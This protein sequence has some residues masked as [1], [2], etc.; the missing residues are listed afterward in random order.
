MQCWSFIAWTYDG[1]RLGK[2]RIQWLSNNSKVRR[3]SA[4]CV[5]GADVMAKTSSFLF[6]VL[7]ATHICKILENHVQ[8]LRRLVRRYEVLSHLWF[9]VWDIAGASRHNSANSM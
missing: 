2:K 6:S 1:L 5:I 8:A 7:S 3:Y 4:G 9:Q